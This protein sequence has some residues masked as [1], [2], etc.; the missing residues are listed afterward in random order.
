MTATGPTDGQTG[1]DRAEAPDA[2]SA[3]SS[4]EAWLSD[5]LGRAAEFW[6]DLLGIRGCPPTVAV[7]A[8]EALAIHH[9]HR[10][11]DFREAHRLASATLGPGLTERRTDAVKWRL[12][13]LER[14]LAE[15]PSFGLLDQ[16]TGGM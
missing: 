4:N 8:A 12:N 13:R 5:Y 9:E 2:G 16:E 3:A 14:R 1:R 7:E 15:Q 6:Q 10:L 11:R